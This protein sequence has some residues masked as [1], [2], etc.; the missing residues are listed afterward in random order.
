MEMT[1]DGIEDA[2]LIIVPLRVQKKNTGRTP[3]SIRAA[4]RETAADAQLTRRGGSRWA[5]R[6]GDGRQVDRT[7]IERRRDVG[8]NDRVQSPL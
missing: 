2:A 5:D 6:R 1:T 8:R 4:T 7:R 3:S